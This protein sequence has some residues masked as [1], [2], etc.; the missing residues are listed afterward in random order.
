MM[1][2]RIDCNWAWGLGSSKNNGLGRWD[3]MRVSFERVWCI[4][5]ITYMLHRKQV[6]FGVVYRRLASL[7]RQRGRTCFSFATCALI[8]M[9]LIVVLAVKKVVRTCVRLLYIIFLL[10]LSTSWL[11]LYEAS[12]RRFFI[13]FRGGLSTTTVSVLVRIHRIRNIRIINATRHC[14][15]VKLLSIQRLGRMLWLL[16]DWTIELVHMAHA[17]LSRIGLRREPQPCPA[18]LLINWTYRRAQQMTRG[19]LRCYNAATAHI[20]AL[21]LILLPGRLLL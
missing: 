9:L 8:L 20:S 17:G 15:R 11:H 19:V 12:W 7:I 18:P 4:R 1:L 13:P 16:V 6:P 3:T 10:H 14:I 21:M 2:L 5:M